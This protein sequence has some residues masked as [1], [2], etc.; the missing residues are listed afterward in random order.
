VEAILGSAPAK[1]VIA[2]GKMMG[3]LQA[4]RA[5]LPISDFVEKVMRDTGYLAQFEDSATADAQTRM[6]NLAELLNAAAQ[7]QQDHPEAALEDFLENVALV[8]DVDSMAEDRQNVTLM[9]VHSAKGLE[10]PV[11]FVIGLEEG[12]FPH[13]RALEDDDQMQEERRL[14]YVAVTRAKNTLF[15]LN[16]THRMLFGG[17]QYNAPSRFVDEIPKRVLEVAGRPAKPAPRASAERAIQY[18]M[19]PIDWGVRSAK[20]EQQR[21]K[22]QRFNIGDKVRHGKFGAG[23]VLSAEEKSGKQYVTVVFETAGIRELSLEYAKLELDE[24]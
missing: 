18:D 17:V 16:C 1:K 14:C 7:Y 6:E 21:P 15:L 9:T 13:Q 4:A 22:Q 3:E 24:T 20:A 23:I 11:V 12:I 19:S 8:S 5:Q 2:F 10:F